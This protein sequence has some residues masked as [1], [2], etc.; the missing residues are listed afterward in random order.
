MSPKDKPG[1]KLVATNRKAR[2]F[3]DISEKVEAGIALFG[4]EVK[5]LRAGQVDLR[6]SYADVERGELFLHKLHLT[7]T[8]FSPFAPAPERKRKLLVRREE[9]SRLAGK[10]SR[11]G[12]SLIPLRLYFSPRG[13]AKVELGLAKVIRKGDRREAIKKR[14]A[15]KEMRRVRWG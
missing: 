14:E 11:Q 9:L 5:S 8:G 12:M 1:E 13:W 10:I 6:D 4:S 7:P 2:Q 15:E 3:Y